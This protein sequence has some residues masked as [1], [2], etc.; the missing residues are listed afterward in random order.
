MARES[1]CWVDIFDK[2]LFRGRL[3]RLRPGDQ[4]YIKKVAS[5]IVGPKAIACFLDK[6]T[7]RLRRIKSG[8]VCPSILLRFHPV[9]VTVEDCRAG[10]NKI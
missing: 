4:K 5:I 9:W 7:K 8:A 1:L 2:E 6:T 3:T 10:V